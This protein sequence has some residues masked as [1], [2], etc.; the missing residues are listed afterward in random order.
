MQAEYTYVAIFVLLGVFIL[1]TA[2]RLLRAAGNTIGQLRYESQR[3]R[4]Q[5]KRIAA[6]RDRTLTALEKGPRRVSG[7]ATKINWDNSD[8]RAQRLKKAASDAY[9]DID[10]FPEQEVRT[11]WGWPSSGGRS[12]SGVRKN[13]PALSTRVSNS[14]KDLFRSKKVVDDAHRARQ[15][16]SIRA[17]FEDRYG[18]VGHNIPASDIEWAKPK[19]PPELLKEREARRFFANQPN[20]DSDFGENRKNGL[21]LVSSDNDPVTQERKAAGE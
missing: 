5:H 6:E 3:D 11:P 1:L 9:R 14:A 18:R 21:K 19:L 4:Q 7:K 10:T 2:W 12:L 20:Q 8:K 17:L 16:H 13:R 15:A